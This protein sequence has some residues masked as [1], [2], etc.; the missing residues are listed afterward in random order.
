MPAT[1]AISMSAAG[2]LSTNRRNRNHGTDKVVEVNAHPVE[3]LGIARRSR[4]PP[5]QM[6]T[7]SKDTK[8]VTFV[9][10][11]A[12]ERADQQRLVALTIAKFEPGM[13]EVVEMFVPGDI[14]T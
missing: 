7:I 3:E 12:V 10:V 11:F 5:S 1:R 6:T 8:L 9:N 4:G 13:Y 14:A 2:S